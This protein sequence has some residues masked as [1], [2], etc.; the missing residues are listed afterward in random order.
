MLVEWAQNVDDADTFHFGGL[1]IE[2]Y[3]V[4]GVLKVKVEK[5]VEREKVSLG[6]GFYGRGT[7]TAS[8][9]RGLSGRQKM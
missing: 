8:H 4:G 3:S 9:G 6:L 2:R 7:T 1:K 5:I